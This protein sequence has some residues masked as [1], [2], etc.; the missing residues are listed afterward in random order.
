MSVHVLSYDRVMPLWHIHSNYTV[1]LLHWVVHT[2][3][4]REREHPLQANGASKAT[5]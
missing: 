1:T 4:G 3:L 5:A 2:R